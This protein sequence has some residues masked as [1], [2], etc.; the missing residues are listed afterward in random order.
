MSGGTPETPMRTIL[1]D[2]LARITVLLRKE[3]D[4]ARSEVSQNLNRAAFGAGMVCVAAILALTAL[5]VLAIA[6][7]IALQAS[8]M[9]MAWAS[10]AVGL[11]VLLAAIV[12][13][14]I[15]L[16]RMKLGALAP[17]R[18]EREMRRTVETVKEAFDA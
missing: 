12:L 3:L 6:A 17:T 8:G 16:R 18:A 10:V 1:A 4:L 14:V 13:C 11:I 15:G 2:I 7:V 5:N 9:D